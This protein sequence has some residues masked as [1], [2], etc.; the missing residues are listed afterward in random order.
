MSEQDMSNEQIREAASASMASGENIRER[1]RALTLQALQSRRLDFSAMREVM[2]SLTQG[3]SLGAERR[4][5]DVRQALS[6]A[7]A[8]MDQA[9]SKAAQA[10]SLALK[11]LAARGRDFSDNELKQGLERMRQMEGDFLDSVRQVSRSTSGSVKSE[12]QDLIAHAQR[13]GTD[14]GRV[15]SQTAR[16]FS[17]RMTATMSEGA[18]AGVEAARQFGERFA[19]LTSGVLAGMSEALRPDKDKDE[20]KNKNKNKKA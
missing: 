2:T 7:F 9:M 5:Q 10:S 11:E 15:I 17:A 3:I 14:T 6:E 19:A 1:V 4:G 18:V 13:A 12:W 20:D 16:D 8:G